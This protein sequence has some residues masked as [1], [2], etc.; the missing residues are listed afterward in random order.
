M[1]SERE[2]DTTK[3]KCFRG[4]RFLFF[5]FVQLRHSITCPYLWCAIRAIRVIRVIRGQSSCRYLPFALRSFQFMIVL[6]PMM[7]VPCVCHRQ[8]GR[9]VNI[10]T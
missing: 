7:N 4:I 5:L 9:M 10:T 6:N 2:T 3:A 8:N 1:A